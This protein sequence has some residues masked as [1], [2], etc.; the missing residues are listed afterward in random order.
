MRPD[1]R[2]KIGNWTVSDRVQLLGHVDVIPFHHALDLFVQSSDYEGTPNVVLEA[3]AMET[4]VV[5]T[6]VGGTPSC[7]NTRSM[8]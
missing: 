8:R 1:W 3:M 6:D 2:R 7:R 5:A 4:P